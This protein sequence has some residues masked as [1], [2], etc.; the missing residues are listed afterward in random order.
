MPH[1]ILDAYMRFQETVET[2][3]TIAGGIGLP[4]RTWTSIIQGDPFSMMASAIM[5]R[6]W[7]MRMYQAKVMPA[8]YVDDILILAKGPNMLIDYA[9]ALDM[10]H[11][12]LTEM[13][14]ELSA[15]KSYN[16]RTNTEAIGWLKDVIWPGTGGRIRVVENFRYLGAKLSA[17]MKIASETSNARFYQGSG[18]YPRDLIHRRPAHSCSG[19]GMMGQPPQTQKESTCSSGEHGKRYTTAM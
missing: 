3:N 19:G 7:A 13:G 1:N 16:F 15:E 11:K 8:L 5:M 4:Y 10:T 2:R 17:G 14:A 6:P 12:Y 18:G 9:A